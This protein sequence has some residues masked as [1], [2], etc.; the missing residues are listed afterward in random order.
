MRTGFQ[1]LVERQCAMI[2]QTRFGG[3]NCRLKE[4]IALAFLQNRSFKKRHHLI[5]HSNVAGCFDIVGRDINKPAA[6]ICN[7]R[8]N[9]AP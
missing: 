9:T 6:V 4:S 8:A 5:K 7:S 3:G 2:K 1:A